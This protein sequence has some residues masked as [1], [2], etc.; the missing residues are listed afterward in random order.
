ME[1]KAVQIVRSSPLGSPKSRIADLSSRRQNAMNLRQPTVVVGQ[2]AEAERRGHQV[3]LAP[4]RTEAARHRL[5]PSES[6]SLAD[7]CCA[8]TSMACEKSAPTNLDRILLAMAVERECH[9]ARA[10]AKIE[11]LRIGTMQ[12]VRK[13]TRGAVPPQT[14]DIHRE[15]VVQQIVA[16]AIEAEH[17][18]DR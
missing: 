6:A 16:G 13:R 18:A 14:V 2:V 9:V 3:K 5:R 7:F 8:R 1:V 17:L 12:Y 15:H 10:A 4:G 11:H